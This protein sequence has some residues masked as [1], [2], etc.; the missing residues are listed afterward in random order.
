MPEIISKLTYR[1]SCFLK[2]NQKT[3]LNTLKY[4]IGLFLLIILCFFLFRNPLLNYFTNKYTTI[5]GAKYHAKIEIAQAKFSG[6]KTIELKNISLQD[7]SGIDS[8]LTIANIKANINFFDLLKTHLRFS[9][10]EVENIRLH[11]IKKEEQDN[12]SFLLKNKPKQTASKLKHLNYAEVTNNM[13]NLLFDVIPAD[14]AIHNLNFT[15]STD[16]INYHLQTPKITIHDGFFSSKYLLNENNYYSEWQVEGQLNTKNKSTQMKLFSKHKNTLFPYLVSDYNLKMSADTLFFSL[17]YFSFKDEIIKINGKAHLEN[18]EMNHWRISPKNVV[19]KNSFV[20]YQITIGENYVQLDSTSTFQ[21]NKINITPFIKLQLQPSKQL[22]LKLH[23]D[24]LNAQDFFESL[25]TGLFTNLEGIKTSGKL[26]YRLNFNLDSR[27]PDSVVFNSALT[28]HVFKILAFG[29]T[30]LSKINNEFSY[31]VYEKDN[32]VRTFMVGS[33]NPF[34]TSLENVSPLLQN[35]ILSSEDGN[36]YNHKGFNEKRFGQSIAENYKQKR[37]VRGGSTI[38]MQLVKNVFL[39]RNK[40]IARKVEEALI[41]W[42]IEN[43]RVVSKS[44]M[45]EVYLNIIELGPNVFGIGE[46]AHFYF[47]KTPAQ[48]TLEESIFISMIVPRPKWFM[49]QFDENGKLKENT[50]SYFNL[51]AGHLVSKGVISEEQKINLIPNIELALPARN[52]LLKKDTSYII[53][54]E[55][56]IVE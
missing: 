26:D 43:N 4:T 24:T 30:D 2:K 29:A 17:D 3:I 13:L 32:A 44:R 54:D 38:S 28:A 27:Q 33:S 40:T 14:L 55:E 39:R 48:L 47:K 8:L 18:L 41:V 53:L 21:F 1:S 45:Y 52:L 34:Y 16:S 56:E 31:T 36:F 25:P 51:I 37:F 22:S 12:F 10:L 7:S 5:Y 23:T 35:S 15:L 42:L 50:S 11:I 9:E 46:A 49:Y 6:L 20:N 19:I